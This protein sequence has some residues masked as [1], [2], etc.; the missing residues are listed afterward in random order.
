LSADWRRA[1][2]FA[3]AVLFLP[4]TACYFGVRGAVSLVRDARVVGW[5][6]VTFP[7]LLWLVLIAA[8]VVDGSFPDTGRYQALDAFSV[9]VV[10]GAACGLVCHWFQHRGQQR[11]RE[12]AGRMTP[13]E[14]ARGGRHRLSVTDR[15]E[16]L[17]R[18]YEEVAASTA[19]LRTG[20]VRTLQAAGQEAPEELAAEDLQPTAP[21]LR[22]LPGGRMT[23]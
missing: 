20:L 10:F 4:A 23:G 13:T 22:V 17:E 7:R 3:A 6:A 9:L 1:A 2:I 18:G 5:G 19:A 14:K 21:I 8:L 16:A 15:L 12:T 11:W